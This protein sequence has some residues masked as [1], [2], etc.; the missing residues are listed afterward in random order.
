MFRSL[1]LKY[2][3]DRFVTPPS[4][5]YAVIFLTA[6]VLRTQFIQNCV[7]RTLKLRTGYCV[8]RTAKT[9]YV[10]VL[11]LRTAYGFKKLRT[12]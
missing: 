2:M 9:A 5:V 6:Y 1:E 7:L 12:A 11:K 4:V 8:L 10:R 3:Y